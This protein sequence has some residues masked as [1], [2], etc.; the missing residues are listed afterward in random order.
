MMSQ[1]VEP[2]NDEDV[3]RIA[4]HLIYAETIVREITGSDLSGGLAD[5]AMLQR[6]L[7]SG[8]IEAE[9]TYALQSLGMALGKVFVNNNNEYDWWMVED[10]YGRDPAV[11]LK[12]TSLLLF[13]QTM[14]SKRVEDGEEVNVPELYAGL[15]ER[16]AEIRDENPEY[17]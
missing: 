11:R 9:A 3:D 5:L 17:A 2:P 13:P 7:D 4:K 10:E 6:V 12:E 8:Q 16:L 14:I 15:I 1:V